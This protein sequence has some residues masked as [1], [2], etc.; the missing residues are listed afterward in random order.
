[1]RR[2]L[3]TAVGGTLAFAL[4]F[5]GCGDAP[6]DEFGAPVGLESALRVCPD[7][8]TVYGIDVSK[9]QGTIDWAKVK[10]DGV[11]YAFIRV[12]DGVNTFDSKF[13]RNWDEAK[14]HGILRGVYQYF[15]PNVDPIE[16]ANLVLENLTLYGQGE[17]PPVIDAEQ[18]VTDFTPGADYADPIGIWIE[19]V[20][21][22]LHV[23]PIIYT[24]PSYWGS[25]VQTD[26]FKDYP[27][28]NANWTSQCPSI[29]DQW[30]DWV[31][32]QY[33]A[34]G[35][36]DGIS[37]DVD[38]DKFNGS[39]ADLQ[40]Y[41]AASCAMSG[42]KDARC[43]GRADGAT[44][45][46][47]DQTLGTCDAGALATETCATACV[48]SGGGASCAGGPPDV[49]DTSDTT[50]D[51]TGADT[52]PATTVPDSVT[53]DS[54]ATDTDAVATDSGPEVTLDPT[55]ATPLPAA[56]TGS[57]AATHTPGSGCAGGPDVGVTSALALALVALV[58]K[59][60]RSR[61]RTLRSPPRAR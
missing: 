56:R 18:S 13:I 1:M 6:E 59:A 47:D 37:G 24:G 3:Q 21:A 51:T 28:W 19:A 2:H 50:S 40:A 33:S 45:C 53:P 30:K 17:L 34:T 61:A 36:V 20:E 14:K 25:K 57:F 54:A 15:R 41:V 48:A 23:K 44:L 5:A 52:D 35:T 26:A 55:A 10:A 58:R 27:L 60:G 49:T 7:G 22:A 16:Q 32:W 43:D 42:C 46:V 9:W 8:E 29:P 11:V 12:S 39:L 31:F 38:L 4:S